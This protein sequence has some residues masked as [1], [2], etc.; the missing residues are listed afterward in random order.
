MIKMDA[1]E[2]W[3][4]GNNAEAYPYWQNVPQRITCTVPLDSSCFSPGAMPRATRPDAVDGAML[5]VVIVICALFRWVK[6]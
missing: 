4:L 1:G 3:M 6:L 2:K 5:I